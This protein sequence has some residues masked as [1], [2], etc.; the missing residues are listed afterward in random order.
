MVRGFGQ[1]GEKYSVRGVGCGGLESDGL[2]GSGIRQSD[3]GS[4]F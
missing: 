1:F 3:S 2:Q 4:G